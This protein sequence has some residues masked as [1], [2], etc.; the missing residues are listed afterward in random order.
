MQIFNK[1]LSWFGVVAAIPLLL[2]ALAGETRASYSATD[3]AQSLGK[4]GS[5]S[6]APPIPV[7]VKD[8]RVNRLPLTRLAQA[9]QTETRRTNRIRRRNR[10]PRRRS[11]INVGVGFGV[12]IMLNL[13]KDR[14]AVEE[15][16]KKKPKRRVRK[17]KKSKK[18][19][20]RRSRSRSRVVILPDF[21]PKELV[22][23][24]NQNV[25]LAV[26]EEIAR[27]YGL[28]R[29]NGFSSA[30]LGGRVQRYR[31]LGNRRMATVIA[32]L[33]TNPFI[34]AVTR[35]HYHRVQGDKSSRKNNS[36]QYSLKIM[37]IPSAHELATGR[38]IRIAIIDA[39]IDVN[40]PAL[41]K[42]VAAKFNAVGDKR[43]KAHSH[44]TA[45][46]GIIGGHGKVQGVAPEAK[47]L[48]IR[49][50][51]TS[52]RRPIPETT[53]FILLRALDA[54]AKQGA[55]IF[56]LSFTGPKDTLV[57]I[58]LNQAYLNG[59]ILIAAAG[60]Q[61]AKA[62]PAYPAAY[63]SVIAIT[64]TD[65]QDRLYKK[66][67]RGQYLVASAPGVDVLV[68]APRKRYSYSSGTSFAA[69][70]VSGLA[71]LLLE[72]DA[73]LS[74]AD[75]KSLLMGSAKD[76]GPEGYDPEF[77][78]GR[79]DAHATLLKLNEARGQSSDAIPLAPK[80]DAGRPVVRETAKVDH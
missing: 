19:A 53:T 33:S 66:A 54:A 18:T 42:V 74:S 4:L 38:K 58:A 32:G 39:G 13:A 41:T 40:H 63:D 78:A 7:A 26:G 57:E 6:S 48:A 77:G 2:V 22:V 45:I 20:R 52:K 28:T 67:N 61:G 79:V 17:K 80:E 29:L 5:V 73:E 62:P 31:V 56:N 11:N 10:R 25:E 49:A 43:Y 70:H 14:D 35:N 16:Q 34:T 21:R 50:F 60:N 46:A 3:K 23:L 47:L 72:Q 76:L 71:A 15:P 24:I 36:A 55:H 44:G 30:L 37:G 8:N 59:T 12:G 9:N 68:A 69:A 64:A 27:T 51:Y 65:N 1:R 75:I